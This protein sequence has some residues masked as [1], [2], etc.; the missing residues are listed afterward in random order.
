[1][2]YRRADQRWLIMALLPIMLLLESCGHSGPAVLTTQPTPSSAQL[3][4]AIAYFRGTLKNQIGADA[5]SSLQLL[6]QRVLD[7]QTLLI[8]YTYVH[9]KVPTIGTTALYMDDNQTWHTG[10]S[11]TQPFGPNEDQMVKE[12]VLAFYATIA[13]SD[14]LL[15]PFTVV[16]G[17]LY[18]RYISRITVTFPS[19]TP[20]NATIRG[21][22]FWFIRIGSSAQEGLLLDA[23]DAH[24]KHLARLSL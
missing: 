13:T 15:P 24:N 18:N 12:R 21:R 17:R 7:P 4:T 9:A 10:S 11:T 8:V 22:W 3:H 5:A 20:L 23:Y 14:P 6:D 1:M 19:S 16:Y 2:Q